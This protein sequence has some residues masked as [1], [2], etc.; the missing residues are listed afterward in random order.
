MK[1]VLDFPY[2]NILVL[3]LA[4]SG[5]AV[6]NLLLNH[7]KHVRINDMKTEKNDPI[8]KELRSLGAE[9]VVGS[10]PLSVL[11]GIEIIVKKS[12]NSL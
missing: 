12:R 1:K 8:I 2:S 7:D 6:A 3:G 9:V 10:H 11:D 4:K 5:T